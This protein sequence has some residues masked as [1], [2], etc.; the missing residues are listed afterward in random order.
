M[1][2]RSR[3][4]FP[5]LMFAGLGC[6]GS[7]VETAGWYLK[8]PLPDA[9]P[10]AAQEQLP[11]IY[12]VGSRIEDPKALGGFG[13]CDNLPKKLAG[14][15]W[16]A[17]GSISIVA[18]PEEPVAYFKSRGFALRVINRS[19]DTVRF[20]A[21]DSKLLLVREALADD[22]TWKEIESP[23]IA[24]CGNSFHRVFLEPGE[25]W[26]FPAREYDGE[27]KTKL[28]FR[29][30]QGGGRPVIYSDE[31]EGRINAGQFL[32]TR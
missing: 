12:P 27:T 11:G 23:P 5:F 2:L 29:L 17:K 19:G 7:N 9:R 4:V 18:F 31:F 32:E 10:V 28:R 16:G 8:P 30:D 13:P 15:E 22:G 20:T 25:Y 24:I 1:T 26:E 14:M 6:Q 21:C 3:L